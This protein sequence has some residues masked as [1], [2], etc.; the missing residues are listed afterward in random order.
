MNS[1]GYWIKSEHPARVC[2]R[3]D[4]QA[5]LTDPDTRTCD[6]FRPE[7]IPVHALTHI[8]FAFGGIDDKNQVTVDAEGV[9]TRLV[10]MKRRNPALQVI[11]AIGGWAFNDP[12]PTRSA[13]T[14]AAATSDSRKA[15]AESIVA[16]LRKYGLDGIDLDWEY[17]GADDRGGRPEDYENYVYLLQTIK[18]HLKEADPGYVLSIAIPASYWYLRHFDLN[19]MQRSVDWFNIMSYDIYGK[20]DQY[21][22]WTGPYVFGHTNTTSIQMGLDLLR[23]NN[24]DLS[25]V[26]LGMGFYGRSFTLSDPK[27]NEPGCVFSDAGEKGECSGEAGILTYKEIMA[28]QNRFNEKTVKYVEKHGVTYMVYDDNQWIGYDDAK[29]FAKKR[30]I[31]DNDCLGGVMIWAIDHDTPDFQALSGLLGDD[32]V[33]GALIEGGSMSEAERE[34]LAAELGGLTGD[35]C[36]VTMGCS[37]P[38]SNNKFAKCSNGYIAVEKVHSPGGNLAN[39]YSPGLSHEVESCSTGQWKNVCCPAKSPAVNCKWVGAPERSSIYCDD[40]YVASTGGAICASGAR[41]LCCDSA[42]ELQKC[43]WTECQDEKKCP[44]GGY[45][46]FRGNQDG[47]K[48]CPKGQTQSFCCPIAGLYNDCNWKP[49]V[50]KTEVVNGIEMVQMNTMQQCMNTACPKDQVTIAK[51]TLPE[52]ASGYPAPCGSYYS[53]LQHRFCCNPPRDVD[54]PFDIKKIFPDS[55]GADIAYQYKDNY[56]N[57]DKD[58][59][60]PDEDEVGDDPYGFVLLDGDQE[61]LQS[62]FAHNFE[63][64]HEDDGTGKTLKKRMTL[65]REDPDLLDWTFEHEESSHLVYCRPNR[66]DLCAQVFQGNAIDTIISLPRHIGSGPFARIVSMDPVE[67]SLL[68]EHH[69]RKRASENHS[70][71]VYKLVFDYDFAAIKR[72]DSTVNIR[73]DYTNLIPYWDEMTGKE[74]KKGNSKRSLEKRWWGSYVD[75]LK[76]LNTVRASDEGRLPMSIHRKMTLYRKRASCARGNT[77]LKAGLDVILDS[78]IDMNARWAYYAQGTIVPL[79]VDEVYTYFEMEPVV[80]AVLEVSGNAEVEYRMK[81]PIKIID[82]LAYPGLAIKGIAAIGPT[83]D[84]LGEMRAKATI[85]GQIRAGAKITF[86]RYETYFPQIPEAS[87]YQKFPTP[88]ANQEQSSNGTDFTPILDASVRASVGVDIMIT[89]VVNLGIKVNH[90]KVNGDIVSAQVQ[91]FV[92]NTFRFEVIGKG[93]AGVGTSPAASYSIFIKYIYNFGIGGAATFKWLG[94]YALRPLQLWPGEGRQKILYEHHG[95]VALSKRNPFISDGEF[96]ERFEPI[97]NSSYAFF[98]DVSESVDLSGG[99][100]GRIDK[101]AEGDEKTPL[102]EDTTRLFTCNDGGKCK[103]GNCNGNSC[104]W[105]PGQTPK[106]RQDSDDEDDPMD[107]DSDT[108]CPDSIPAFMYNC[109][110]FPDINTDGF[111]FLGICHNILNYFQDFQGGGSGPFFGTF[112]HTSAGESSNRAAVCG[113]RSSTTYASVDADGDYEEVTGPWDKRCIAES[114]FYARS[115]RKPEGRPGNTNWLSCDEFP[116]N[117][118]EEGGNPNRNARACVPGYQQNVQGNANQVLN[119]IRQ[120]VTWTDN[121]GGTR[122]ATKAWSIDWRGSSATGRNNNPNKDTA[123]NW[124]LNNNKEFTMHLFDSDSDTDARGEAYSIFEHTLTGAPSQGNAPANLQ[125][126]IANVVSAVNFMDNSKYSADYNAWCSTGQTRDHELWGPFTRISQCNVIFDNGAALRKIKRGEKPTQEEM[127][128][129]KSIEI[130]EEGESVD[131]PLGLSPGGDDEENN[132][133]ETALGGRDHRRHFKHHMAHLSKR[134]G[135]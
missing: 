24:V 38:G 1:S 47:G 57:N 92:N 116:F 60:G 93:D 88:S 102:D 113:A 112:H 125:T 81:E 16:T 68:T 33:Q 108:P 79:K 100:I 56:G 61:A 62:R 19:S 90:P 73:I 48:A 97:Y 35:S 34:A 53:G 43:S 74:S 89:P 23:R 115:A 21:N 26:N 127:F 131:I 132:D 66:E 82:T 87:D 45:L 135:N 31:L 78:K 18:Q 83:L 67:D 98:D 15:F 3:A 39:I 10:K 5:A 44:H 103:Q 55:N 134:H 59:N 69:L 86:P 4:R 22:E 20:W 95:Q 129:I 119:G 85:A 123:W 80:Q 64:V 30:E 76:K 46:T 13:F 7:D 114:N 75:W 49:V 6:S 109:K 41:S 11:L 72:E 14:R 122:T 12:G 133:T 99:A 126:D 128:N 8:N 71:T 36:Y 96:T 84:L 65:T 124:A 110:Y 120:Q 121:A 54:L 118:L 29:S 77:R 107:V 40:R 52:R 106:K 104:Q 25:K 101:R 91:G 28:R 105:T 63:F 130:A 42:P 70:S 9:L 37:G 2:E 111:E 32:F 50:Q 27:C 17:P 94:S 117:A 58:P 51:A